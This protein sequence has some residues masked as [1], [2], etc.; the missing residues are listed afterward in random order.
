MCKCNTHANNII[1][2]KGVCG[3][4]YEFTEK[5]FVSELTFNLRKKLLK[6]IIRKF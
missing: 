6:K 1:N 2:V 3:R 5:G 4:S